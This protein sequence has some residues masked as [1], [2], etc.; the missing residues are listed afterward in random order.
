ML[1]WSP[2]VDAGDII[3]ALGFLAA[4]VGLLFTSLQLREST[5]V[6]RA[7]FL[8]NATGRYFADAEVRKLYYDID[9]GRF[10]IA[11]DARGEPSTFTRSGGQPKPFVGSDEERYLDSLL[12]T[13]DSI[14]RMVEIGALD[15]AEAGLFKFQARRVFGNPSVE[16]L[17][18]WLDGERARFGG[19]IP[20]HR[21]GRALAEQPT[22]T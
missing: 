9:Y 12:Y 17:L 4:A 8:L 2:D 20:T 18:K 10:T 15:I 22:S 19:E 16:R 11:F 14:G 21:A 1:R 7:Q 3:T 6:R 5:K 13:F